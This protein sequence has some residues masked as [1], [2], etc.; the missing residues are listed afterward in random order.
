M[1]PG[2]NQGQ[3]H[4]HVRFYV[5]LV[6]LVLGGIFLLLLINNN[7]GNSLTSF[8]VFSGEDAVPVDKPNGVT[9]ETKEKVGKKSQ[10]V[11][12]SLTF[13]EAPEIKDEASISDFEVVTSDFGAKIYVNDDRLELN[14]LDQVTIKL[15][16]FKGL[17]GSGRNG[18]SLDGTAKSL[19]VNGITLSSQGAIQLSFK[20]LSYDQLSIFG[21]KLENGLSFPTGDGELQVAEK[22]TY[23]LEKDQ[24]EMEYFHGRL[25]TG[26]EG[27]TAEGIAR[28]IVVSGAL[29]NMNLK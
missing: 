28:G 27:V 26:E 29:L 13:D 23:A 20:D 3:P 22:L 21:I 7:E 5:V 14:N 15:S 9:A 8:A 16:D 17:F 1:N 12:F 11:E 4:H 10:E 18:L 6:T 2:M 24:L 19:E 25:T